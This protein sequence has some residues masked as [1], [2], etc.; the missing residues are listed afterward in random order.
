ANPKNASAATAESTRVPLPPITVT[1]NRLLESTICVSVPQKLVPAGNRLNV[2]AREK[3]ASLLVRHLSASP[4]MVAPVAIFG[5]SA[6]KVPLA[7]VKGELCA[8][9]YPS[10]VS[11]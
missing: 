8:P 3:V 1:S 9:A 2:R 5:T 10:N 6:V 11:T 7:N 4:Q